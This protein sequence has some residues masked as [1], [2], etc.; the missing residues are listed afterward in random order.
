MKNAKEF[1]K[2]N[3]IVKYFGDSEKPTLDNVNLTINEGEFVAILGPSGSGKSTLLRIT[4]GLIKPDEGE[5]IL[6]GKKVTD[7]SS[8]AAIVFQTFALYPWMTVRENVEIGLKVKGFP[9]EY[10]REKA[11]ELIS[12]IG[13]DGFEEAYPKELSGGMR[14]RVG[15]ARALAVQPKLLCLDEPFS[16]LDYQTRLN[17]CNDIHE[18]IKSEGKTAV[19]VTHDISEAISTSDKIILLSKRPAFIKEIIDISFDKSLTPFQR[20]SS[21]EFKNYFNHIWTEMED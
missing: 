21:S 5:V 2:V 19:M 12:L 9:K 14:Q 13:L 8:S 4:T 7:V 11:E 6:D 18:I 15:F 1:I 17:V 16:A 3:N 20:R 10:T